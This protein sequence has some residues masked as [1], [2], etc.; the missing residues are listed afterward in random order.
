MDEDL[1]DMDTGAELDYAE[2]RLM[3]RRLPDEVPRRLGFKKKWKKWRKKG[4]KFVRKVKKYIDQYGR[5]CDKAAVIGVN[6][7]GK[8]LLYD[9]DE[10]LY[11]MDTGV[12]LDVENEKLLNAEWNKLGFQKST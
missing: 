11:D 12:E 1:Y 9:M 8:G 3:Q 6:C 7:P 2:R 4:K 10:D 5:V